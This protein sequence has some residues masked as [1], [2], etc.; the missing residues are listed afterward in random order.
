MLLTDVCG[1]LYGL[2]FVV[3]GFLLQLEDVH[4]SIE[5]YLARFQNL[6]GAGNRRYIQTL[7]LLIRALL[8]P[9][10]NDTNL[11]NTGD[12]SGCCS[13][14]IYDFLFSLSIDNINLVKLLAYIK[15][16]NV[17]HKVKRFLIFTFSSVHFSFP[18]F[19]FQLYVQVCGYGDRVAM[20]QKD[21]VSHEET[22]KL[23]SFRAFSDMLV[24]LTHNN[25]D[26]R[27]IISKMSSSTSDQQGGYIK[28]VMLTGAKLFSEVCP[29]INVVLCFYVCY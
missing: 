21:P 16:S 22:S 10:A 13:M 7:L 5:N 2:D 18:N 20:L 24:A 8:K 14:A 1:L 17:I 23:T 12:P 9:L 28:Y 19:T 26:G 27:M 29:C 15:E 6:L 25:G 11:I 3:A 4:C